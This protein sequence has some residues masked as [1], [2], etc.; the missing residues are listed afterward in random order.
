MSEMRKD[1]RM[2]KYMPCLTLIAIV[3][4]AVWFAATRANIWFPAK[5]VPHGH[6]YV[7][8]A[9]KDPDME[10]DKINLNKRRLK[11]GH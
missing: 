7:G 2:T 11:Y 1:H 6:P 3:V 8:L 9:W 10:D 5:P 4:F